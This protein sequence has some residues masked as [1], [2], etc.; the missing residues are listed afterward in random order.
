M[1]EEI[2]TEFQRL[3][4]RALLGGAGGDGVDGVGGGKD[5]GVLRRQDALINAQVVDAAVK[6]PFGTVSGADAQRLLRLEILVEVVEI[7]YPFRGPAVE[8]HLDP[9]GHAG[10]VVS[11]NDVTPALRINALFGVYADG[12]VQPAHHKIDVNLAVF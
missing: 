4:G 7:D 11:D 2:A 5:A 10:A 8:I 6:A 9:L 1:I 12:V 3:Q